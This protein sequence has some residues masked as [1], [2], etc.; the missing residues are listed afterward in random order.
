MVIYATTK[1][2]LLIGIYQNITA[3][4]NSE[5]CCSIILN[6]AMALPWSKYWIMFKH[7]WLYRGKIATRLRRNITNYQIL[8]L[9]NSEFDTYMHIDFLYRNA[10]DWNV[11]I[12]YAPA[13]SHCWRY[14]ICNIIQRVITY[15]VQG[16][17]NYGISHERPWERKTQ[18]GTIDRRYFYQSFPIFRA[19]RQ[20]AS[21]PKCHDVL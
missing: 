13:W 8:L 11:I 3:A 2:E 21:Q 14:D 5:Y 12:I 6:I 4:H 10:I 20:S 17:I 18:I 7:N 15:S 9:H 19:S 1:I 16:K